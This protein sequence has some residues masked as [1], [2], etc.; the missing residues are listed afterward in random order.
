MSP[1]RQLTLSLIA[2]AVLGLLLLF[3]DWT[4]VSTFTLFVNIGLVIAFVANVYV[5]WSAWKRR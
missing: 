1:D 4:G 5:A 3:S 2:A